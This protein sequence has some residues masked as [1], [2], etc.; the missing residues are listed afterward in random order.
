MA[1]PTSTLYFDATGESE[2]LRGWAADSVGFGQGPVPQ[3]LT[4][5]MGLGVA[6]ILNFDSRHGGTCTVSADD[7]VPSLA[8]VPLFD[9]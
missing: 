3:T 2:Q 4:S 6:N 9:Q 7:R 5:V 1:R 8:G